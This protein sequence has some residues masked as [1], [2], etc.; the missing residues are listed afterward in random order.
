M[1]NITPKNEILELEALSTSDLAGLVFDQI[2]I[3]AAPI[4]S[5]LNMPNLI[6]VNEASI[7]DFPWFW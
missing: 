4:A 1:N 6:P 7:G 5:A 3:R 2:Q